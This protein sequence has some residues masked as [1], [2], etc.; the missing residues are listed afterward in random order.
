MK[1]DLEVRELAASDVRLLETQL[2]AEDESKYRRRFQEHLAGMIVFLVA[3]D[4]GLPVGHGYVRWRAGEPLNRRFP[5]VPVIGDLVVKEELRSRGIGTR[6]MEEAEDVARARG[7]RRMAIGVDLANTRAQALYQR[8]GYVD[9]G[10]RPFR[11]SWSFVDRD[12]QFK[13]RTERIWYLIKDL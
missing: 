1:V 8:R 3:W 4:E 5:K 11:S 6:I 7:R 10:I 9:S 13:T 12:G 2:P